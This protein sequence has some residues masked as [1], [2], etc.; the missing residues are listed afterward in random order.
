MPHFNKRIR[1]IRITDIPETGGALATRDRDLAL[2]DLEAGNFYVPIHN[3]TEDQHGPYDVTLS[4]QDGRL[5]FQ[6][7]N[8][9]SEEL[10]AL[11]L[12]LTPYR[13]LIKDYFMIVQSYNEAIKGANPSRIE[14]IDM[15]RRGLHNEG[16][17][18]L[19]ERLNNKIKLDIDTA[20]RIFTLI[21][22]LHAGKIHTMR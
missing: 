1:K 15:G 9:K 7:Q 19:M 22:V 6:T 17:E 21:C 4:L 11:V 3:E 2:R 16:A 5:V 10:P 18:L 8:A 14:A 20:R 13:R 12:S